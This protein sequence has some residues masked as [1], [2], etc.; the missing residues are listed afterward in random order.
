LYLVQ[1]ERRP[2]GFGDIT[3]SAINQCFC[4]PSKQTYKIKVKLNANDPDDCEFRNF[5]FRVLFDCQK[6][7]DHLISGDANVES[8]DVAVEAVISK[9][10]QMAG[11]ATNRTGNYYIDNPEA[12][13]KVKSESLFA[14]LQR[15]TRTIVHQPLSTS[16]PKALKTRIDLLSKGQV[17]AFS[18]V[19]RPSPFA[20]TRQS[21]FMYSL[22]TKRY[23]MGGDM[24]YGSHNGYCCA[25]P[26]GETQIGSCVNEVASMFLGSTTG[27]KMVSKASS[28]KF[29]SNVFQG[30]PLYIKRMISYSSVGPNHGA[31]DFMT[32]SP[33]YGHAGYCFS[34]YCDAGCHLN[35]TDEILETATGYLEGNFS[36]TPGVTA[37]FMHVRMT[38]GICKSIMG[39]TFTS[40][41]NNW[42]PPRF[43]AG[44]DAT[45]L[46]VDQ[47]MALSLEMNLHAGCTVKTWEGAHSWNGFFF[48]NAWSESTCPDGTNRLF[49]VAIPVMDIGDISESMTLITA[50]TPCHE[51][52]VP[53]VFV[54]L[55]S[56]T[57]GMLDASAMNDFEQ[58]II[59]M[60][61]TSVVK[62]G[63]T[64]IKVHNDDLY[65]VQGA[66]ALTYATIR[67]TDTCIFKY[68]S[69]S[70]SCQVSA[71][72]QTTGA[73]SVPLLSDLNSCNNPVGIIRL[74]GSTRYIR[75][76]RGSI[77]VMGY[78][79]NKTL[80][81]TGSTRY[82][83]TA[84]GDN[85]YIYGSVCTAEFFNTV[86]SQA[87]TQ[88]LGTIVPT[89]GT[90]V[91]INLDVLEDS[92]YS[93]TGQPAQT[94]LNVALDSS[95][96]VIQMKSR[97]GTLTLLK[98]G[99]PVLP[100]SDSKSGDVMQMHTS[101]DT[102]EEYTVETYE[103]NCSGFSGAF[104]CMW[105]N[106]PWAIVLMILLPLIAIA[107]ALAICCSWIGLK[108]IRPWRIRRKLHKI[109][110][111]M[112]KGEDIDARDEK[113]LAKV[114][115]KQ[116]KMDILSQVAGKE[117]WSTEL[118][119]AIVSRE[120]LVGMKA[121][122]KVESEKW[123]AKLKKWVSKGWEKIKSKFPGKEDVQKL[124]DET[125]EIASKGPA[126][127]EKVTLS[128]K[129]II[130]KIKKGPTKIN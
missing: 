87:E 114:T 54:Q 30:G 5:P 6:K 116:L 106:Q 10:T 79:M 109:Y 77:K 31:I 89:F 64:D 59:E 111:K 63:G 92:T 44:M 84:Q 40:E 25:A 52:G 26:C 82:D 29:A 108:K 18:D 128:S 39:F 1:K 86:V 19:L 60:L 97:P 113:F 11:N 104:N 117:K 43:G 2:C 7:C 13:E 119:D 118:I 76:G 32:R 36:F 80:T 56:I 34:D 75:L 38:T 8:E 37:I 3:L 42:E 23:D 105:E 123:S 115:N 120:S 12:V 46:P 62:S 112:G 16:I 83:Y 27:V 102:P 24:A 47:E 50:M 78:V 28:N 99:D 88:V 93:C 95:C 90:R 57:P 61:S 130:D 58:D 4:I 9:I 53:E 49:A 91:I 85:F 21:W 33:T 68:I 125:M 70:I 66:S 107:V 103:G 45:L 35:G 98:A 72:A 124:D 101:L 100:P 41:A 20:T 129:D 17:N 22:I 74:Q 96:A 126:K 121:S 15:L 81:G 127:A 73:G 71:K 110:C 65:Q 14:T 48:P 51:N 122:E 69:E 67:C 55:S 94:G